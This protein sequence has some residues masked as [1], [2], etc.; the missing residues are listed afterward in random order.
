MTRPCV[1]YRRSYI[2]LRCVPQLYL[3]FGE[4]IF[5]R[6]DHSYIHAKC[7]S[8]PQIHAYTSSSTR[9]HSSHSSHFPISLSY[10]S[11][12]LTFCRC[13][14]GGLRSSRRWAASGWRRD[15]LIKGAALP[16]LGQLAW[17]SARYFLLRTNHTIRTLSSC[18]SVFLSFFFF[19]FTT[20]VI[21]RRIVRCR[22][23]TIFQDVTMSVATAKLRLFIPTTKTY[24]SG[25]KYWC[26]PCPLYTYILRNFASSLESYLYSKNL[27][28]NVQQC[29]RKFVNMPITGKTSNNI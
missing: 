1:R 7:H 17:R 26:Y 13:I 4:P 27:S 12:W 19:V 21:E 25:T 15:L 8:W 2:V 6:H 11:G 20:H 28:Q 23:G 10:R 22:S 9:L 5:L 18:V 3:L 24:L 14:S 29:P 16:Y